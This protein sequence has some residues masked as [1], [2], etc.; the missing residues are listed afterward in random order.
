MIVKIMKFGGVVRSKE[1]EG[2]SR[3]A[4]VGGL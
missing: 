1:M 3:M 4:V 2:R